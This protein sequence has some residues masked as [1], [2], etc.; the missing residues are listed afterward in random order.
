MVVPLATVVD[1][2]SLFVYNPATVF[3]PT[4][5]ARTP[6]PRRIAQEG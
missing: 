5:P 6:S 4:G 3:R 1:N 2:Q